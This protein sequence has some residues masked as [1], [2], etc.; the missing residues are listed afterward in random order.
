MNSQRLVT[1]I[2]LILI[3]VVGAIGLFYLVLPRITFSQ[4]SPSPLQVQVGK[5][6]Y[7]VKSGQ[8]IWVSPGTYTVS[9]SSEDFLPVTERV[10]TRWFHA[11]SVN[12]KLTSVQDYI[13]ARNPLV[14]YLPEDESADYTIDYQVNSDLSVTYTITLHAILNEPS[15]LPL[16]NQQLRQFK[17]EALSWIAS[18]GVDPK[19]LNITW[20]PPNAGS[21]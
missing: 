3:I 13:A 14:K 20:I 17:Q 18:K 9:V 6:T 4:V 12:L 1:I 21:L 10:T 2:L 16:Y 11:A 8:T 15:Q 19:S 5:K 7:H